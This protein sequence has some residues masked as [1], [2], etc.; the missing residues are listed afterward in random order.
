[1][2]YLTILFDRNTISKDYFFINV[3]VECLSLL[4]F[5]L[6]EFFTQYYFDEAI[7]EHALQFNK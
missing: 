1:M 6:F 4:P 7:V 5:V 2:M 3:I